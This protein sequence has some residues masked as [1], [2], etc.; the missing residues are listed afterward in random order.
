M[1]LTPVAA[2]VSAAAAGG[3]GSSVDLVVTRYREP[4][5]WLRPYLGRPGW[6]VYIYNT[7]RK[8]PPARIYQTVITLLCTKWAI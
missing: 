1:M 6:R 4:L 5:G 2:A 7:G 8:P 3:A